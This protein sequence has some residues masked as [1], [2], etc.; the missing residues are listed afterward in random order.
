[1]L[2]I[3]IICC[4]TTGAEVRMSIVAEKERAGSSLRCEGCGKVHSWD[5][6]N[7]WLLERPRSE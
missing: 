6:L 3:V 1:M 5:E 2:G 7:A 4:P